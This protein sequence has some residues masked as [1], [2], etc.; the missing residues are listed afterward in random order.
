M[1]F[2]NFNKPFLES[3]LELVDSFIGPNSTVEVEQFKRLTGTPPGVDMSTMYHFEKMGVRLK[4]IKIT[5]NNGKFKTKQGTLH[6]MVGNIELDAKHEFKPGKSIKPIYSGNGI[7]Y[8]EPSFGHFIIVP[9][10]G[11]VYVDR[12]LWIACD[13]NLTTHKTLIKGSGLV[14]GDGLFQTK[15]EGK[16]WLALHMNY[17]ASEIQK[18][19]LTNSKLSVDGP[20]TLLRTGNV[21]FRVEL[22]GKGIFQKMSN[23]SGEGRLC[24]FEGT[25]EVWVCPTENQ[26]PTYR[27]KQ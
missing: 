18:I 13:G 11:T 8:L 26:Y 2:P 7:V 3:N 9:V 10:D 4:R 14:G 17:P 27:I 15:I 12:G 21:D 16:G 6:Y 22:A 24:V 19:T 23:T 1:Y 20:Y 5:L 25:G